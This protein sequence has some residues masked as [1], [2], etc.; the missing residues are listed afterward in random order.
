MENREGGGFLNRDRWAAV[1][2]AK[3]RRGAWLSI[4]INQ[5]KF[6]HFGSITISNTFK[7]FYTIEKTS[8]L[9]EKTSTLAKV[10]T[11]GTFALRENSDENFELT[12]AKSSRLLRV[13]QHR[14]KCRLSKI[15]DR[16]N[17]KFISTLLKITLS[18][19]CYQTLSNPLKQFKTLQKAKKL[20]FFRRVFNVLN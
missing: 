14:E 4:S 20:L 9:V 11:K 3:K 8:N 13:C 10:S 12:S 6:L 15:F 5:V 7:P 1:Q 19:K 17:F 16:E 18:L 2:S